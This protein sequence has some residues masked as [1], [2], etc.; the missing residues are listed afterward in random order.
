MKKIFDL[1]HAGRRMCPLDTK[2]T[3]T[4][5]DAGHDT[6]TIKNT[7]DRKGEYHYEKDK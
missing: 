3:L 2:G 7:T 6:K 1:F 4:F 5:A